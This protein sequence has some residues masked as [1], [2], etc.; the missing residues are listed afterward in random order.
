MKFL[1]YL[2]EE[3]VARGKGV[4]IFTNPTP[5]EL[6]SISGRPIH[7]RFFVVF[8]KKQVVVWDAEVLHFPMLMS[9]KDVQGILGASGDEEYRKRLP[10]IWSG[11][12]IVLNGKIKQIDSDGL[13]WYKQYEKDYKKMNTEWSTTWFE[14]P[15]S[16]IIVDML[17]SIK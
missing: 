17:K 10:Q 8:D 11:Y 2:Q 13:A 3:Y 7:V 1:N 4:E 14:K 12:G 9:S 5:K 6:S 15:I 16:K